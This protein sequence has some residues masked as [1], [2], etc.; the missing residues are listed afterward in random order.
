MKLSI[1]SK[2]IGGFAIVIVFLLGIFTLGYYGLNSLSNA[3]NK[4]Y[5]STQK[6]YLWQVAEINMSRVN[7]FYLSVALSKNQANQANAQDKL[8][9]AHAALDKLSSQITDEEKADLNAILADIDLL[10]TTSLDAVQIYISGDQEGFN[11]RLADWQAISARLLG[12]I[13]TQL[14]KSQKSTAAD[15]QS[16]LDAKNNA[17]LIMILICAVTVII[18]ALFAIVLSQSISGRIIAVRKAMQKMADGDLTHKVVFKSSDETGDMAN[19]YN[20]MQHYLNSLVGQFK[21]SAV[22]LSSAS[23]QLAVAAK[24]SSDS[25]QQVATSSQ[26]MAKGAQEQSN[27]AQETSRSISQLSE[28]ISHL[29]SGASEQASGVQKAVSS[30]TGVA[31]TITQ[32]ADNAGQAAQ[33]AK[34]AAT[35]A[36][37]GAEMSRLTLSGMEKI[38]SAAT[39]TAKKIEELGARS[40]EIGKIVAVIDDIAAQTNLLA[41]NAAI[42]AARAGDQGRGFAVVSDEVRKLAE[43]TATATKEIAELISSVQKGVN[44]ANQ[45]MAAGSSAVSDGYDMAVKAGQSLEQILKTVSDVNV[46]V[47][48]ISSRTQQVNSAT[49]DLVK[50]IDS[51]GKVT[52]QNTAT[53]EQMSANAVQVSKSVETVAGIAEE[54]SAATEQV[55]ASAQEMSAQVEEIVASAQT[56]KEMAATLE[57]SVAMFKVESTTK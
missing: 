34:L 55:S 13:D 29:A 5:T 53:T 18:A 26:Q 47:D 7:S 14:A 9:K 48:Q 1:K 23:D 21:E 12:N 11:A 36:Q 39:D 8:D 17:I 20:Q 32:V 15:L 50:I 42:E 43:R 40:T 22:Q 4:L 6:E 27:N 46:Q 52:E 37:N 45:V 33:G 28:A 25:T 2:L 31:N 51:V 38:K 41:L 16:S 3:S 19:A 49:N 35:S 10:N 24:Q 44:E 56:L 57:K 30:I 54:N